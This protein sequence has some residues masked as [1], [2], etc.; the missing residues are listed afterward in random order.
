MDTQNNLKITGPLQ[1]EDRGKTAEALKA[2]RADFPA[3]H[4]SRLPKESK[5]QIEERKQGQN[6]IQC[7]ECGSYHHKNAVHLDYVGHAAITSRL[8][9]VDP[10]WSWEPL[11]FDEKG[12]PALD[13]YQGM[14]IK[15]T[16]LGMT[17]LGY[18]DAGLKAGPDAVKEVIGD[19]IRNAAMRFGAAL[20][21]WHKGELN[22]NREDAAEEGDTTDR[23]SEKP[24]LPQ[25]KEAHDAKEPTSRETEPESPER[26]EPV[27][28]ATPPPRQRR[29]QPARESSAQPDQCA[30]N[31]PEAKIAPGCIAIGMQN[32]LRTKLAESGKTE[33]ALC[34]K[35]G[36]SELH[37][38]PTS[39]FKEAQAWA[40]Q[41]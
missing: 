22:Q 26:A 14:W 9:D 16:V 32:N 3:N 29:Q 18:G 12:L 1:V 6:A 38:L 21:L 2:M 39:Q 35:F 19:A 4:V 34:A 36:I 20:D 40:Q 5:R 25:R 41:S 30:V 33:A 8:L 17:R 24:P 28:S 7:K 23:D 37:L 11:S 27:A 15:L 13:K 10:F 31:P